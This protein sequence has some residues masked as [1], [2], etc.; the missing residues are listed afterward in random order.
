M[1][2]KAM[3]RKELQDVLSKKAAFSPS[4][5]A[6]GIGNKL[7]SNWEQNML[8]T[9]KVSKLSVEKGYLLIVS[10]VSCKRVFYRPEHNAKWTPWN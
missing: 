9:K 4:P 2:I 10:S 3:S 8:Y 6:H 7:V 1:A 5:I